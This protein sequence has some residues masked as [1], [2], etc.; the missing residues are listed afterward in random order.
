AVAHY[1]FSREEFLA[2]TLKDIRPAEDV[3]AMIEY[4]HQLVQ[5]PG[6]TRLGLAGVWRHL[7]RNGTVID[8]EI[9]WSPIS[10]RGRAASLT[11]ANA[12]TERKRLEHRDGALSKLGQRLSPA[13]PPAE[14]AQIIRA[15]TDDLFAWDGFILDLYS[16]EECR[17]RP[18]LTVDTELDGTQVERDCN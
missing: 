13:T 14:A 2:M 18:I 15:V 1:G 4:F 7:K 9:K 10:F 17:L 3:P 16:D 8:V 11:M 6:P 12:V 5:N